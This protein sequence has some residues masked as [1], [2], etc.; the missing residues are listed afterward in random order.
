MRT[1]M[2]S[3]LSLVLGC[4]NTTVRAPMADATPD[5]A[6]DVA[7]DAAPEAGRDV[8]VD[9]PPDIANVR[10][11]QTSTDCAWGEI[12][13][14][15]VRSTDCVC[16]LGCPMLVLNRVTVDRRQAQY[17]SLCTPGRDGM[18][19]PCPIDDCSQP[20][21]LVCRDGACQAP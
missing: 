4:S 1:A 7:T 2:L 20:P 14:E 12:D 19:N 6:P 10:A 9:V 11:C 16:L 15:I 18:G 5:I 17:R 21:P 8:G 13:H 3:L